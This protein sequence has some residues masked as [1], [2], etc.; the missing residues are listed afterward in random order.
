MI[1]AHNLKFYSKN[2]TLKDKLIRGWRFLYMSAILV[3]KELTNV[4]RKIAGTT[5]EDN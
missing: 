3:P 2:V 1:W 5:A 4:D